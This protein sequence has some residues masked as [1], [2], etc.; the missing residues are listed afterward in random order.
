MRDD[1]SEATK[2]NLAARVAWKCSFPGCGIVTIG[3]NHRDTSSST[4]LGEAAHIH[5]A[6]PNG[7]RY[8]PEMSEE[9]RSSIENGIWL[10]RMHARLIDS[11]STEYSAETIKNWKLAAEEESYNRLTNLSR[12]NEIPET[13]ISL[14][15]AIIFSGTWK[16]VKDQKWT[17]TV[18]KFFVGDINGLREFSDNYEKSLIDYFVIV[19]SQGDGRLLNG[20]VNWHVNNGVY[21]IEMQVSD[22]TERTDPNSVGSDLSLGEDGD[23]II[24]DGDFKMVSGVELAKQ[25]LIRSLGTTMGDLIYAPLFGSSF[26]DYY[27]KYKDNIPFL[28]R[29][30]KI[31]ITRLVTVPIPDTLSKSNRPELSFIQRIINVEVLDTERIGRRIPIRVKLEWGNGTYWEETVKIYVRDNPSSSAQQ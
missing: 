11:D 4:N 28:N 26:S 7:P 19:E 20:K 1:F 12:D 27:W 17:F 21:E 8:D 14:G 25:I 3:P 5:A 29:L 22:K 2:K 18:G 24:E 30:L 9:Q 6:S 31:E 16:S 13:L 15:N 10:C 23:L